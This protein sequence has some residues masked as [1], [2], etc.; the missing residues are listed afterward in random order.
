VDKDKNLPPFAAK[1]LDEFTLPPEMAE[2]LE[3]AV[4][5][6]RRLEQV[7]AAL[8]TAIGNDEML[9]R[10]ERGSLKM[11]PLLAAER[12]ERDALAR[13]LRALNLGDD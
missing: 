6:W 13:L 4:A 5:A 7:K 3:Q 10:G 1:I 12:A 2:L 9:V 11:T 8:D